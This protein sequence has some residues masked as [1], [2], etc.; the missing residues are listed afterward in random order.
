MYAALLE[1]KVLVGDYGTAF[2]Q[3]AAPRV[4]ASL[5]LYVC[6]SVMSVEG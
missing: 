1:R 3:E 4:A 5:V 6:V 2:V